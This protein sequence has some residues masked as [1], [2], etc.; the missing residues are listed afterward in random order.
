MKPLF[1]VIALALFLP[2]SVKG[3][4]V[5]VGQSAPAFTVKTLAGKT[6]RLKDARGKVVLLDFW[7]VACP[8]CKI[9]MPALQRWHEQYAGRGMVVVGIEAMGTETKAIR[10]AL[11]E[12]GV[13][14]PVA[15]DTGNRLMTLYGVTAHPTTILIDQEGKI[16]HIEVGYVRGDEKEIEKR[17]L[18]LLTRSKESRP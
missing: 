6:F 10:K 8:P 17:L 1:A 12:R 14:Y 11:K 15:S 18:P 7:G 13:T 3:A 5:K 16:V 2:L 9:Q 4:E